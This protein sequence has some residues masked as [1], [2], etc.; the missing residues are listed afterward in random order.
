MQ[1]ILIPLIVYVLILVFSIIIYRNHRTLFL[2]LLMTYILSILCNLLSGKY[3]DYRYDTQAML[4]FTFVIFLFIFPYLNLDNSRKYPMRNVKEKVF[5]NTSAIF[6]VMNISVIVW[7]LP[8]VISTF[9]SGILNSRLAVNRLMEEISLT[10]PGAGIIVTILLF[11]QASYFIPLSLFFYGLIKKY[12]KKILILLFLS[13]FSKVA[14]TLSQAGR[15]GI[16][17]WLGCFLFNY[18]I[19]RRYL[20]KRTK[21]NILFRFVPAG[22]IVLAIII[23]ITV[24][25]FGEKNPTVA[26]LDYMGQGITNFDKFYKSNYKDL[27]YGAQSLPLYY[28][29]AYFN[30]LFQLDLWTMNEKIQNTYPEDYNNFSTFLREI[31]Y[32]FG[33]YGTILAALFYAFVVRRIIKSFKKQFRIRNVIFIYYLFSIPLFGI[34]SLSIGGMPENLALLMILFIRF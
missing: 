27:F 2:V 26:A 24:A 1:Q 25:R 33:K 13:S 11:F 32:D 23:I 30:G 34:F 12:K 28:R 20:N 4:Y 29:V 15:T 8:A 6:I 3:S 31:W 19:F 21:R 5:N 14:F 18:I 7:F 16:V 9:S 17:Y 22:T 10:K